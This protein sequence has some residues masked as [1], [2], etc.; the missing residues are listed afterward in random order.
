[1]KDA[2]DRYFSSGDKTRRQ[3]R[4]GARY[5]Q[6]F[7]TLRNGFFRWIEQKNVGFFVRIFRDFRHGFL[8]QISALLYKQC[9]ALYGG[10]NTVKSA[11]THV[12]FSQCANPA[13]YPMERGGVFGGRFISNF[14]TVERPRFERVQAVYKIGSIFK[15][16]RVSWLSSAYGSATSLSVRE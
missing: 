7:H 4:F 11:Q 1:M 13:I 10:W 6:T 9:S 3:C 16:W 12:K 2:P 8:T 14:N 15:R 5:C